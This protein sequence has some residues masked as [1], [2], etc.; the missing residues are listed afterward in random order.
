MKTKRINGLL[1]ERMLRNGIA[2]LGARE[3]ELNKLNVF[4][5]ADGDTGTN[6][7]LTAD[8]GVR[9]AHSAEE[10]GVYLKILSEGML[11]GA[12][13]NSGVILSQLFKGIYMELNRCAAAS[14]GDMRNALIRAY[15]AAYDS[16]I[17]P[18]EG[19]ILTVTRE[20]I[21]HIRG[22]IDRSTTMET[23][24][25]MYI[26]E[27]KKTLRYTPD[28]LPALK[29]AGVVDSGAMGYIVLIEG[30]LK[31][32]YGEVIQPVTARQTAAAASSIDEALFNENS[33]F[34]DGYCLEFLLQLMAGPRYAER[35][36]LNSF[37]DDMGLY[38]SSL[39][40]V[41]DGKRV[42]VHIHT[43]KP[44]RVI[45]A[46]QEY[47]EFLTFKLENMQ[48]QHNERT[49]SLAPAPSA[50]KK[51]ASLAV[52]AAVNGKGMQSLY[53]E[54]GCSNVIDSGA[55]MNTSSQEFLEAIRQ[56]DADAIVVLPNSGNTL[57]AAEQAVALS[58]AQ[59]I[60]VLPTQSTVEGYFALAMD[61]VDS[62]DTAS[63]IQQ[64]QDGMRSVTTVTASRVSREF[65]FQG[66]PHRVGE[67]I[68]LVNG[69]IAA[70]AESWVE[71]VTAAVQSVEDIQDKE[72]CVVFRGEGMPESCEAELEAALGAVCPAL[73]LSFLDGGQPV[74]HWQIGIL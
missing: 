5:V 50:P 15:R 72:S 59:N 28:L 55:T 36:R 61:V 71:A 64:M 65:S 33:A 70:V 4:P 7:L 23:L 48:L 66:R 49:Q 56:A 35:F 44:A 12:R 2:N 25:S 11:L 43:F 40:V 68:A 22:Q 34:E 13:G 18:V 60:R 17:Q 51:H 26:A 73:E 14:P 32:L 52:V 58:G 41:Q 54:L 57:R 19:T 39:V 67:E 53:R 16:V 31:Y 21:E 38:G 10:L 20:G 1:F 62:P 74:Y 6:M 45:A 69:E 37:I 9:H 3:L 42:K 47:G 8:G 24:F 27:M 30:M 29:E 46:S 63:R